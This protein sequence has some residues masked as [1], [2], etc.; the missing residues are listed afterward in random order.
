[1]RGQES[2]PVRRP[3]VSGTRLSMPCAGGGE[4]RGKKGGDRSRVKT[5]RR[6][7]GGRW[8]RALVEA[9]LGGRVEV[10]SLGGGRM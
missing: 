6:A 9:A 4:Y 8:C 10:V 7:S 2:V 1:V 3:G 5:P